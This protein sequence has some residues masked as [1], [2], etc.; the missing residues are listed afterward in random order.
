VIHYNVGCSAFFLNTKYCCPIEN[1][2]LASQY[3]PSAA[4]NF[5]RITT[6]I[7]GKNIPFGAAS[8]PPYRQTWT[9]FYLA[10]EVTF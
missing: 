4:G 3:N 10:R 5:K 7:T 8:S 2:P 1:S 6:V 9:W